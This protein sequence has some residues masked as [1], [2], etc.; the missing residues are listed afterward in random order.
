MKIYII[1]DQ[2]VDTHRNRSRDED[3]LIIY[4]EC[5]SYPIVDQ[6]ETLLSLKLILNEYKN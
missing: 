6:D 1:P 2:N 3:L 5:I 4:L